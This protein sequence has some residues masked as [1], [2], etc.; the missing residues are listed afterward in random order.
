MGCQLY[1]LLHSVLCSTFLAVLP[2]LLAGRMPARQCTQH[3]RCLDSV[4][5]FWCTQD[6]GNLAEAE[7]L[8]QRLMDYGGPAITK[9][10]ALLRE[11]RNLQGAAA[12]TSAGAGAGVGAFPGTGQQLG[13]MQ[14]GTPGEQVP[15]PPCS[16]HGW[17][18]HGMLLL[19][20]G[21]R[22]RAKL[23]RPGSAAE[24]WGPNALSWYK[25][26]CLRTWRMCF[27]M[28]LLFGNLIWL[29]GASCLHA[30]GCTPECAALRTQCHCSC[31]V[32]AWSLQLR[33]VGWAATS[34]HPC[35]W[36]SPW[37]MMATAARTQ[38]RRP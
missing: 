28:Q 13:G 8:C 20:E 23:W 22:G 4:L 10:K 21:S 5:S 17:W 32:S 29:C 6:Q 2:L 12:G 33:L 37:Q 24:A 1:Q 18:R 34:P 27:H 30:S 14:F 7:L 9:A 25:H 36:A 16:W 26:A 31:S 11:I 15:T 3:R 35:P 38:Q 19:W